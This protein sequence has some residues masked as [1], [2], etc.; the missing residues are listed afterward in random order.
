MGVLRCRRRNT[1][2]P[3]A[4]LAQVLRVPRQ[5]AS[6][7]EAWE[8][9]KVGLNRDEEPIPAIYAIIDLKECDVYFGE[10]EQRIS[11]QAHSRRSA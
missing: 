10:N 8:L 4:L 11:A 9:Q 1:D 5:H 6:V 3:A 2:I 7:R